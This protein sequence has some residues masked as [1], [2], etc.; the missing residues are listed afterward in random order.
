MSTERAKHEKFW[1]SDGNVVLSIARIESRTKCQVNQGRGLLEALAGKRKRT[2]DSRVLFRV[3]KSILSKHSPVFEGM[4][5]LPEVASGPENA[6][7]ENL[8]GSLDEMYEGAPVVELSDTEEQV[9]MLLGVFY[10]P[11]CVCSTTIALAAY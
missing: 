3:H 6:G 2:E 1:F 8:P 10:D 4:F 11:L 9:E 7:A 5:A